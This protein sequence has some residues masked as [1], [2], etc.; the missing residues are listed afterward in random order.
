MDMVGSVKNFKHD[1]IIHEGKIGYV[2][3]E[4]ISSK[5]SYGWKTIFAYYYEVER[6]ALKVRPEDSAEISIL[7]CEM[8]YAEL[9]R[10]F[11]YIM[12]VTGTLEILADCQK[13]VLKE[14]Y[15]INSFYYMP[16]VYGDNRRKRLGARIV[17]EADHAT[18]I[19]KSIENETKLR[20]PVV[21]FFPTIDKMNEFYLST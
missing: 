20:R 4:G 15:N 12:G 7:C 3:P 17:K 9:P 13:K 14:W 6:G 21:V 10:S 11:D 5:A 2:L 19:C 16:S 18:E 1:Y 8:S